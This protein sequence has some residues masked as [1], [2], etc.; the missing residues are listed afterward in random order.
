MMYKS[1]MTISYRRGMQLVLLDYLA[2]RK[3]RVIFKMI[4][5]GVPADAMDDYVRVG[6]CTTLQCLIKFVVAVGPEY[7][8]LPNE[9]DTAKLLA[10]GESRGFSSMLGSID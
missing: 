10:I 6:E 2:Y 5:Y 3:L 4:A 9:Q 1:T 8:R 7:L